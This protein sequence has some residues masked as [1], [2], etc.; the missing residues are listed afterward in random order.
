MVVLG[1]QAWD[2]AAV[3]TTDKEVSR[4]NRQVK[5]DHPPR[6]EFRWWIIEAIG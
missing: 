1:C 5:K 3:L 4:L 2:V 6:Q